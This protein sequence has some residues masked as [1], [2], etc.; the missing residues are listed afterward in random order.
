MPLL[1]PATEA[2][3]GAAA[4]QAEAAEG[5]SVGS[6][7][8]GTELVDVDSPISSSGHA[9]ATE[10]RQERADQAR[11][12]LLFGQA[13]RSSRLIEPVLQIPLLPQLVHRRWR[14]FIVWE[15]PGRPDWS[16]VHFS[17]EDLCSEQI[18]LHAA[19]AL[20]HLSAA[21][22]CRRIRWGRAYGCTQAQLKTAYRQRGE[23]ACRNDSSLLL[24][25]QLVPA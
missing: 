18:R 1:E 25:A 15:V 20:P 19:A 9:T 11:S 12:D 6:S 4:A 16:G 21:D 7:S 5:V 24:V 3:E 17:F 8:E 14:F 23:I 13:L 22:A 2:Q 10:V